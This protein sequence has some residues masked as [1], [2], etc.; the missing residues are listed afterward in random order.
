ML[1]PWKIN[2]APFNRSWGGGILKL[3]LQWI[4]WWW[5][6]ES[7]E[8]RVP[9]SRMISGWSVTSR[10]IHEGFL[11]GS[12]FV[13][14]DIIWNNPSFVKS[15]SIT[16]PSW[17]VSPPGHHNCECP[18]KSPVKNIARGF[19]ALI[20]EYRFSKFNKKVWN[21]GDKWLLAG[22]RYKIVKNN[23]FR[24]NLSSR[25]MDSLK[26]KSFRTTTGRKIL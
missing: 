4:I 22:L 7:K 26:D 25:T 20:F 6:Y 23:F 2:Y 24:P 1:P 5:Q 13:G 14:S 16:V 18:L 15:S 8:A 12:K 9:L 3:T 21:S 19:S 17:V 10:S 11:L